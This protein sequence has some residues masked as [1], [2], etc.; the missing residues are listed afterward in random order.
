MRRDPAVWFGAVNFIQ[1]DGL[2]LTFFGNSWLALALLWNFEE[3]LRV[4]GAC[5]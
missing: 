5:G 2:A 4:L 1:F 3:M